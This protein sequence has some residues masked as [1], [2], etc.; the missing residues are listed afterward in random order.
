M[1]SLDPVTGGRHCCLGGSEYDFVVTSTLASQA[2]PAVG[3]ALGS[4]LAAHI[5]VPSPFPS[6]SVSYVSV[7]DGSVNNAHF[8]SATNLADYVKYRSFRCP[9]VFGISDNNICISLPV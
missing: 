1:S 5:N 4:Q 8:L 6:D 7:G 3:R 9:V 2:P